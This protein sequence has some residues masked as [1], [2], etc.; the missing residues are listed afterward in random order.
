M[1]NVESN[2]L[3]NLNPAQKEAVTHHTGPIL[4]L[5]GAGTGKT[6]VL[7]RRVANLIISHN[8]R[9]EEILAVTFTNKATEE[10]KN[11]LHSSLGARA[12]SIW[13]STFHSASLRILRRHAHLLNYR[14]NF[15]IYDT[16]D[17]VAVVKNIIKNKK[18]ET[19][20]KPKYFLGR[21]DN[22]KNSYIS[23]QE[24]EPSKTEDDFILSK[25]YDEYQKELMLANA[26]DFTDLIYNCLKLLDEHKEIRE[27]Y[28]RHLKFILVDEF[29]DTNL[30]QY[31][32][33]KHL[34]APRNNLL[35][36]G[37]DD[38]SIYGFRG[39]DISNILSFEKDF[40]DTKVVTLEQNYRSTQNIL[41]ASYSV[42]SKNKKRKDKKIWTESN[43]GKPITLFCGSSE[44]EE[45]NYI[46][47]QISE[48]T[49]KNSYKDIAVFY[50]TNAQSRALEEALLFSGISYKI[51]GGMKFY[52]RMEVK[53]IL[54]YLRLI[55]NTN[56]NQAFTRVL[57]TPRRGIGAATLKNIIL[58]AQDSDIS[59][60]EASLHYANTNKKLSAFCI[61]MSDL[62]EKSKNSYI[63]EV[64]K[65]VLDKTNYL[66]M[67]EDNKDPRNV[68]RKE[69][70]QELLA[71]A[72][73]YDGEENSLAQFLDKVAL[74][75]AGDTAAKES[76]KSD[77]EEGN[78]ISLMTLHLAKGLEFPFVFFTGLEEGLLPHSRSIDSNDIPEERRLCYVGITRAM[79]KLYLTY[80]LDRSFSSAGGSFGFGGFSRGMSR[81]L[82]DIPSELLEFENSFDQEDDI[83]FEDEIDEIIE[84]EIE[85][86]FQ[87]DYLFDD[88]IDY[89]ETTLSRNKKKKKESK[90]LELDKLIKIA[91]SIEFD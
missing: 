9:P 56:D 71:T 6:R 42:I 81:F 80:A 58:Y 36:V 76:D 50:R 90:D 54:A 74:T 16:A 64:M 53:D 69:N 17:S 67:F 60:W 70:I 10:M 15:V 25:V 30:I 48:I 44:V 38:Q 91:D 86:E 72:S 78:Y 3:K 85:E 83:F 40:K 39:A 33:V 45:A 87:D 20:N 62:I 7:T 29:Q 4:V 57:N 65:Q 89:G 28:Q 77:I 14:N 26:M 11:R 13:I 23:S 52:E 43:K 55:H 31:K 41:E 5:A 34:A 35:V 88:D 32:I 61:L 12:K 75:T 8:V 18:I 59:L 21:I 63:S 73:K 27:L 79:Q 47:E 49:K 24:F 51:F 68:E 1:N 82:S 46:V 2:H 37:D 22:L 66:K 84:K 19:K